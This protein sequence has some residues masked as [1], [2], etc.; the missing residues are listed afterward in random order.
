MSSQTFVRQEGPAHEAESLA[1]GGRLLNNGLASLG[2][3]EDLKG[4]K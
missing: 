2:P 1:E 3:H 4:N